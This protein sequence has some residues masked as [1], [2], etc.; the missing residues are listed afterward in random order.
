M[1]IDLIQEAVDR[2]DRFL[3]NY[4]SEQPAEIL[5]DIIHYCNVQGFDLNEQLNIAG[6]YVHEEQSMMEEL[7]VQN[8]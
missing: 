6:G 2:I 5:A 3:A 4:D 7:Y 1:T 8:T